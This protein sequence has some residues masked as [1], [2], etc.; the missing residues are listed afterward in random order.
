MDGCLIRAKEFVESVETIAR[1]ACVIKKPVKYNQKFFETIRN[2]SSHSARAVVPR[3]I[4][5]FSP[6]SVIDVGC[7]AGSWLAEFSAFGIED[8]LGIDGNASPVLDLAEHKFKQC[9]LSKPISLNR[10]FDL[11][12]CLEVAEH[13]P[14]SRADTLVGDLVQLA[15]IVL[16]SAAIPG[17]GGTQHINERWPDY[18][19]EKFGMHGYA[20]NDEFRL[21]LWEDQRI[22]WWYRQ[23]MM[24]YVESEFASRR[25]IR[26]KSN[27][28]LRLIHPDCF[29]S[30]HGPVQ[31]L[32]HDIPNWVLLQVDRIKQRFAQ[33]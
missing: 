4:N 29:S 30:P 19:F 16:F 17:Q 22:E 1:N 18:W 20:V 10:K 27:P 5:M 15:P 3:L 12:I 21:E 23:N 6:E 8:C 2:G 32:T 31:I 33:R 7:G 11:A 28:P 14:V 24:L 25:R 13:L 9:D 26:V